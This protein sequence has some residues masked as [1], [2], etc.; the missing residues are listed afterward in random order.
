MQAVVPSLLQHAQ[1][2]DEDR[3]AGGGGGFGD[4]GDDDD[5]AEVYFDEDEWLRIREQAVAEGCV[6]A[7]SRLRSSY[8]RHCCDAVEAA[9]GRGDWRAAEAAVL[10]VVDEEDDEVVVVGRCWRS[11]VARG[12][13]A[14]TIW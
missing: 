5:F 8:L 1:Y 2:I 14:R 10:D 3:A 6:V 4:D 11:Q 7:Y 13:W 9:V 12:A